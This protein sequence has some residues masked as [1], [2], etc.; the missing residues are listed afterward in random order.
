MKKLLLIFA[1]CSFNVL[2]K[3]VNV[4]TADA[5]T[6]S[7]SLSGVGEKKAA[8]IVQYRTANGP[9]KSAQDL[10]LVKGI[11]EKTVL[12][13]AS[14]ILISDGAGKLEKKAKKDQKSK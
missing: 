4:N 13:N 7:Q 11:G 9:F 6:I 3:P 12:K 1:L 5:K 8:A 14:D 2:A 10:I